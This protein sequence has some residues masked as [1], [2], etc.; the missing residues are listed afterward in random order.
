MT[1]RAKRMHKTGTGTF[2]MELASYSKN[3]DMFSYLTGFLCHYAL[4]STTHPFI[5]EKANKIPGMHMAIEHRLDEMELMQQGKK[6]KDLMKLFV[7]FPNLPEVMKAESNV[8]GW[9]KNCH[10]VAYDYMKLYYWL[11]IDSLGVINLIFRNMKEKF[12]AFSRKNRKA[13]GIDLSG[14]D[15][16]EKESEEMAIE[17]IIAAYKYRNEEIGGDELDEHIGNRSYSGGEATC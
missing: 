4:D 16:L 6:T 5:N 3:D 10:K 12:G 17:L 15:S 11:S 8:Y 1:N 13:N 14:F 2:L 7:K 9:K